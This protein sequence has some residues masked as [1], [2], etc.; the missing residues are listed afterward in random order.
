MIGEV[1]DTS[2]HSIQL[3]LVDLARRPQGS[4]PGHALAP[5][6]GSK[7]LPFNIR[8]ESVPPTHSPIRIFK[9]IL[10]AAPAI[11]ERQTVAQMVDV[12]RD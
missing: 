12:R 3:V 11:H 1:R 10:T 5:E 9:R 2:E 8:Y 4:E 6:I 7:S